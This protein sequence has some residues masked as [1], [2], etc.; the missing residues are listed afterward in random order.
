MKL[1][2]LSATM[3]AVSLA[4]ALSASASIVYDINYSDGVNTGSG[5]IDV[6]PDGGG[7]F[8]AIGGSFTWTTGTYAGASASLV[9]LGTPVS[10][11]GVGFSGTDFH[12]Y[13]GTQLFPVDDRI[14]PG[15]T[16]LLTPS[17]G[18]GLNPQTGG[19]AF[20]DPSFAG[21]GGNG[22]AFLLYANYSGGAGAYGVAFNGASNKPYLAN[23]DGGTVTLD[24][25]PVPEPT[26]IIAGALL[27]LPFGVS[28][29]RVLRKKHTA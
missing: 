12:M 28:V 26:T 17:G 15:Q 8:T 5:Q 4:A 29:L 3:A 9:A 13:G 2:K 10:A 18:L 24:L 7:I 19:L 14:Y 11:A 23:Y 27:L 21:L 16:A 25:A 22:L 1:F 20:N 6:V